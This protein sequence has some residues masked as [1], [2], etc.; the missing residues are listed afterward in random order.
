MKQTTIKVALIALAVL[1]AAMS[2][3]PA[4]AQDISKWS[5]KGKLV[6]EDDKKAKDVSG[7]ACTTDKG[8][9][10]SCLVIDD[11]VQFAQAVTLSDGRIDVGNIIPL[12]DDK[13]K[14]KDLE[15]D[16]EGVA[17]A[18]GHFYVIGSHG[19][20]RDRNNKL[21]PVKDAEKIAAKIAASS[22]LVRVRVDAGSGAIAPN[23][24]ADVKTTPK[25]RE[26]IAAQPVL[27]KFMD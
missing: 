27:A 18:G 1:F 3:V 19:H 2:A 26:L 5:V 7:I 11:N 12:I 23:G 21:D 22:K 8:F 16:G 13:F 17:F 14:G 9:P 4:F 24:A 20:P 6:G 10:R 25:L 15:L